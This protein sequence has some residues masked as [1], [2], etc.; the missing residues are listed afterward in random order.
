[1][2][3]GKRRRRRSLS[4]TW[5]PLCTGRRLGEIRLRRLCTAVYTVCGMLWPI[6]V[7]G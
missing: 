7:R 3:R 5:S 6:C 1:V 4:V 2:C